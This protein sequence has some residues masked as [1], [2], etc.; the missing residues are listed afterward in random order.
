[1]KV[2]AELVEQHIKEEE[3]DM[4]PDFK[5]SSDSEVRVQ[6]GEKYRMLREDLLSQGGM[7]TVSESQIRR[8]EPAVHA[9]H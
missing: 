5:K 8:R 7:D 2:L 6:L 3:E 1:V 4:L 9:T